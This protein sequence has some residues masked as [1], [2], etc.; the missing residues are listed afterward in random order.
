MR[1]LLVNMPWASVDVPSLALG[2]LAKAVDA[3]GIAET[4]TLYANVDF[5]DWIVE[6]LDFGLDDYN[7]YSL[8][9][10]FLGCGDWVFSS[11][12]YEDPQWRIAE[13]DAEM[14]GKW[15]ERQREMSL[16][17]HLLAP[18]FVRELAGRIIS[19]KP[20]VVGFTTTFQQNTASLATAR[21]LK[22][23]SPNI[24]TVIGGAN[25][26]GP[27]GVA[28]H[29][30]FDFV[31]FVVRGEGEDAFPRMLAALSGEE[32]GPTSVPGLCWRSAER[33]S[34]VNPM[35]AKPVSPAMLGSP[36]YGAYF[37]C[38]E[39]SVVRSWVEPKLVVESARGCWWGEK[40]H[41]TFCGLNGSLMEFRSKN[42][43]GFAEEIIGLSR[44]HQILDMVAVDN[45]LDMHYIKSLMP[46]LTKSGYDFRFHYEV[47]SN[48]RRRQLATLA[49][50]GVVQ[51]QPG[52][53]SLSTRVLR[54]MRKGVTG[55][56]NVRFL[57]D[58]Q[59]TGL[60]S[61]WN[62]L[63]GF[64]GEHT[65][66]YTGIV[67]QLPILHHLTPPEEVSRIAIER[68]SPYFEQPELGF[69]QPLAARQYRLIYDL[70]E[71][72]I[73]DFAYLFSA[74]DRGISEDRAGSLRAAIS[75]WRHEHHGSRVVHWDL[76][77][78]IVVSSRRKHFTYSV[79]KI[80]DPVEIAAF[81]LLD[82]PRSVASLVNRLTASLGVPVTQRRI[83]EILR[84]WH[85]LGLVFA[86]GGQ[87]VHVVP[88]ATNQELARFAGAE[89]HARAGGDCAAGA[90]DTVAEGRGHASPA[91]P[92]GLDI[93]LWRDYEE[94]TRVLPEMA[95]GRMTTVA[96]VATQA[97]VFYERG[98]RRVDL[99]GTVD[100]SEGGDGRAAVRALTLIRELTGWGVVVG[101]RLR[102][103]AA[104][105]DWRPLGHLYPPAEV[106]GGSR[107]AAMR[108]EWRQ[109][110][111]FGKLVH[112]RGPGFVEVRDRRYGALGRVVIDDAHYLSCIARL[113]DGVPASAISDEVL[114][115]FMAANLVGRIG[116][117]VW[118][119]PYQV[120]RWPHPPL[121]V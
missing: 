3:T 49:E 40:H 89:G 101:W 43:E 116:T 6:R 68:F 117:S 75:E 53:E 108:A 1:V 84:R 64:P 23:L 30:N 18:E 90:A 80:T 17:L 32:A 42:P 67:V 31:D 110:F 54:L 35:A 107:A 29:R 2:A 61:A 65:D 96:P 12:L 39:N 63:Y 105:A 56:Q 22:R 26:D 106:A 83:R 50:G 120:H 55:C 78:K 111:F 66:D 99:I 28:L 88:P 36:D 98:A 15:S 87:F 79:Q 113:W 58:A 47:K 24:I 9:T 72:E 102:V 97:K 20:D 94:D 25:C 73:R 70:P 85:D 118:W 92:A 38:L 93:T 114:A 76:D 52:I 33:V 51:V 27:Q 74:T 115:A 57:R 86:D 48:L 34:N 95:L 8:A 69:G 100:L 91:G 81:R 13:Y 60:W 16:S 44:R 45:I 14:T 11:A 4:D 82:D 109:D 112:R 7:Y 103:G 41:C 19:A 62:Y 5:C 10:Y 71:A 77:D 104:F 21:E 37:A 119:M 121:H 59:A 46:R